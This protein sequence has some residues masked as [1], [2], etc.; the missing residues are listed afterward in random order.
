MAAIIEVREHT[1]KDRRF[2]L[3]LVFLIDSNIMSAYMGA[4]LSLPE[5]TVDVGAG[6]PVDSDED[7]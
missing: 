1:S 5:F 3:N 2:N 4:R 6:A 7:V